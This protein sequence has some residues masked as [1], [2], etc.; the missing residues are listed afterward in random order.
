MDTGHTMVV[1]FWSQT[2]LKTLQ[3]VKA[4]LLSHAPLRQHCSSQQRWPLLCVVAGLSTFSAAACAIVY[5][6]WPRR[7]RQDDDSTSSATSSRGSSTARRW[8]WWPGRRSGGGEE[9]EFVDPV[10]AA[11]ACARREMEQHEL[12]ALRQALDG[13]RELVAALEVT[14]A[15][16]RS[17]GGGESSPTSAQRRQAVRV[18]A[19]GVQKLQQR[20]LEAGER[21]TQYMVRLDEL[22]VKG[23]A[24]LRRRRKEWVA[25]ATRWAAELDEYHGT[26]VMK[27]SNS[28]F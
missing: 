23:S 17:G 27:A 24:E 16:G 7:P 25:E 22:P 1:S 28:S 3:A 11:F 19:E 18:R 12:P 14:A 10:T 4:A 6:S 2:V 21:L 5:S 13:V 8:R 26:H 20:L 9:V 15:S